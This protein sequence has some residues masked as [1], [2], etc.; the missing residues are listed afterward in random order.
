[1]LMKEVATFLAQKNLVKRHL[2]HRW[3]VAGLLTTVLFFMTACEFQAPPWEGPEFQNLKKKGGAFGSGTE[4]ASSESPQPNMRETNG[5]TPENTRNTGPCILTIGLRPQF[6]Q[7]AL[8]RMAAWYSVPYD[9]LRE[10]YDGGNICLEVNND[11]SVITTWR[12]FPDMEPL[13]YIF[14]VGSLG[15]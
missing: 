10:S 9:Q 12:R 4:D 6:I 15:Y 14:R 5:S 3:R 1:M 11:E 7:H 8:R 2:Q 13:I